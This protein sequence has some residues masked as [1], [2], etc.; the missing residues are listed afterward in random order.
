M[1]QADK[2]R[3]D[4]KKEK[5]VVTAAMGTAG[6]GKLLDGR[7]PLRGIGR[8]IRILAPLFALMAVRVLKVFN[9]EAF[10]PTE[11]LSEKSRRQEKG[12]LMAIHDNYAESIL[13]HPNSSRLVEDVV[14]ITHHATSATIAVK[15]RTSRCPRPYLRGRLSGPALLE[16][17]NWRYYQDDTNTTVTVTVTGTYKAPPAEMMQSLT[18]KYFVDLN[19]IFCDNFLLGGE[20]GLVDDS[21]NGVSLRS[22]TRDFSKTCVEPAYKRQLTTPGQQI[23]VLHHDT[24][25]TT[26]KPIHNEDDPL[27]LGYW[28]HKS[29]HKNHS[30]GAVAAAAASLS[31]YSS[32]TPQPLY[33]RFQPGGCPKG[34]QDPYCNPLSA[35]LGP[36]R[37]YSWQWTKQKHCM[38]PFSVLFMDNIDDDAA[39][40]SPPLP[41]LKKMVKVCV[42]GSSHARGLFNT[43]RGFGWNSSVTNLTLS[44]TDKRI[45]RQVKGWQGCHAMVISVGQWPA[46]KH[47]PITKDSPYKFSRLYNEYK[48]MVQRIQRSVS[49]RVP[50]LLR[51]INYNPL[52]NII[53]ACPPSDW[54]NPAVIDGYNAIIRQVV[55]EMNVSNNN[56]HSVQFVDTNSV[57]GPVWDAAGDW[58]HPDPWVR[59]PHSI[60]ILARALD[61]V[62]RSLK[63]GQDV[64]S[65]H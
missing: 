12:K 53:S 51:S 6:G 18:E 26:C 62:T 31:V 25:I 44:Y 8:H 23:T 56:T 2:E 11:F 16:I 35:A 37:E 40:L 52:G 36:F 34:S 65:G 33:M 61:A 63:N 29:K 28:V 57:I 20:G 49:T 22:N 32:N 50:I 10:V 7:H 48:S 19:V 46:G 60:Y 17:S 24:P 55:Q 4:A 30:D 13:L 64:V 21:A 58:C 54:R 45:P 47:F 14:A 15:I 43:L 3:R 39:T 42:I 41:Q 1:Q 38:G 9:F 5:K 27:V 59:K